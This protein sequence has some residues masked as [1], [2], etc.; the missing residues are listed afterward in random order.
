MKSVISTAHTKCAEDAIQNVRRTSITVP[1]VGKSSRASSAGGRLHLISSV[2]R[3]DCV[4]RR[5]LSEH[6]EDFPRLPRDAARFRKKT[7]ASKRFNK[8]VL[9]KATIEITP[10]LLRRK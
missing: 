3:T 10:T 4:G 7:C 9:F 5:G 1:G 8:C 6:R 2:E